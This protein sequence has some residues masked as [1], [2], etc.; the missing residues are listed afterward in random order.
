MME[1]EEKKK[2]LE[3]PKV[4]EPPELPSNVT[5]SEI[6]ANNVVV[7]FTHNKSYCFKQSRERMNKQKKQPKSPNNLNQT[8]EVRRAEVKRM[9]VAKRIVTLRIVM[10][11]IVTLR[12]AMKS[13]RIPMLMKRSPKR[14]V[15]NRR[16]LAATMLKKAKP[17]LFG[18]HRHSMLLSSQPLFFGVFRN[19]SFDTDE[20]K[21]KTHFSQFG[22]VAYAV[23]CRFP[24]T[25]HSKGTLYL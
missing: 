12:I 10:T 21:L 6:S 19:L 22:E 20:E 17:C 8:R 1:S 7:L 14:K 24:D 2:N 15:P 18:Q 11:M 25:T 23:I 3:K 5:I 9:K 4:P 16:R 13:N